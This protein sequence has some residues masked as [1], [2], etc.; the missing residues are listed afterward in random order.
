LCL[1]YRSLNAANAITA[2]LS[3]APVHGLSRATW[4]RVPRAAAGLLR[5]LQA[6]FSAAANYR[7]LRSL[8]AAGGSAADEA[9]RDASRT[10]EAR[11]WAV[12]W[13]GLHLREV[14]QVCEMFPV[15]VGGGGGVPAASSPVVPADAA[16]TA[17]AAAAS[18]SAAVAGGPDIEADVD[19]GATL[20]APPEQLSPSIAAGTTA[21]TTTS[22]T[23]A[24]D[25][26]IIFDRCRWLSLAADSALRFQRPHAAATA[27]SFRA[28]P[29]WSP[30]GVSGRDVPGSGDGGGEAEEFPWP[31]DAGV[32]AA[33]GVAVVATSGG[34][35][36]RG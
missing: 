33:L 34:G 6:L 27:T 14:V 30:W 1:D 11:D 16:A 7:V 17:T 2:A 32:A 26:V 15:F 24:G 18:A 13:L 8:L 25:P 4:E 19:D 23:S 21:T 36:G 22:T 35:S 5:S 28:P 20:A 12:P 31:L 9:R 10:A 3:S 29:W